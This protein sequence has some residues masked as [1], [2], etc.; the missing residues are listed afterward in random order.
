MRRDI[1][2]H[3]LLGRPIAEWETLRDHL[4]AVASTASQ[5]AAAF[6][7]GEAAKSMGQLHDIGKASTEFQ[8][9]IQPGIAADDEAAR[10]G[11]DHSTA[12]ARVAV[13]RY[14]EFGKLLAYGIAGHH[15]GLGDWTDGLERRLDPSRCVIPTHAGWEDHAGPLPTAA[16][17]VPKTWQRGPYP[18]FSQSFLSR[19]LFSSLVDADSLETRR[20]YGEAAGDRPEALPASLRTLLGIVRASQAQRPP[21]ISAVDQLRAEVLD[22]VIGRVTL[23]PGLFTFTVPKGGGKMRRVVYVIP[24]TSI[25]EQT[26]SVFRDVLG[27]A[28]VL[29]HHASFDWETWGRTTDDN[30]DGAGSPLAQ[31]QRA[32]ENWDAPVVVTTAVQFFE[33]LFAA[34]R[35]RCRKLHNLAGAV[36]VLDEAQTLPLPLLQPCLAALDEL[37]RN[38]RSSVVLCT[39]TQP[40]LRSQDDFKGGLNLP[41]DRE[42]APDP[43]ALY[44][45]LR[46]VR[47]EHLDLPV[48]DAALVSAFAASPQVLCIVNRRDHAAALFQT[49]RDQDGAVHLS[50][51]M[52]PRHRRVVLDR[53]R[54]RLKNGLP[55]RLVATSLMEAGVDVDFPEVWREMAGL[56]SIAQAAGRC[57]REG[58]PVLGRVVVFTRGASV[59]RL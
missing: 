36:I 31:L 57:N 50:T 32:A 51:L 34:R 1:F 5:F 33:S 12:G 38:Y 46:R 18:G 19:M 10:R 48:D 44:T 39:A 24:Y 14:G 8:A 22:H 37:A 56:D 59:V 9:Y 49:I 13:Q 55:V 11:G 30:A 4:H 6:G 17:L 54:A 42:L 53:V 40:A 2:A 29:E 21:P 52:C 23:T 16:S 43:A 27:A 3:S 45:R 7:W 20:F 15:A 47:V 58:G 35:A 26:A 25:I 41:D 28:N